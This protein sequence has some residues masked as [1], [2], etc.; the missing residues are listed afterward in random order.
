MKYDFNKMRASMEAFGLSLTLEMEDMFSDYYDLLI[1][2]NGYMNLTAI[3]EF[4]MVVEKHFIDS[5]A[6]G[7]FFNLNQKLKVIDLGTG[8][9]FPGLPLKIV[10]PDLNILLL[11]S[12]NK[13]IRFLDK[14]IDKLCLNDISALHG[15]AEDTAQMQEYREQYQLCLSR[16]VAS[17]ALLSEYCLPFVSLDGFFISYKSSE[18]NEE[19][20]KGR[21]A[22]ELLGGSIVDVKN[23][24]LPNTDYKRSIVFIKKVGFTNKCYPRKA[25]IPKKQPLE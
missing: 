18:V 3:T 10:F 7:A 25:G 17:M 6:L 16:A 9:G 12:L 21:G 8:A 14:V 15:R 4:D 5:I 20:E 24:T 11:D 19:L 1:E 2:W 22:I 13:R 23:Y